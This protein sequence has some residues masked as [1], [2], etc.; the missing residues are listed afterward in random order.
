MTNYNDIQDCLALPNSYL[1]KMYDHL[2]TLAKEAIDDSDL[3]SGR[4]LLSLIICI[5]DLKAEQLKI[6]EVPKDKQ[7]VT[8]EASP[9]EDKDTT[10]RPRYKQVGYD[11][12]AKEMR[13][14]IVNLVANK[15]LNI[16]VDISTRSFYSIIERHHLS[17]IEASKLDSLMLPMSDSRQDRPRW[18]EAVT[19][20]LLLLIQEGHLTKSGRYTY[21]WTDLAKEELVTLGKVIPIKEETPVEEPET[22]ETLT[23]AEIKEV[24]FPQPFAAFSGK[25]RIYGTNGSVAQKR[26]I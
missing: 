24:T 23:L 20:A 19:Q 17:N 22:K 26:E 3:H 10:L 5:Q 13:D 4:R 16:N 7:T 18:K 2:E 6:P 11:E 9:A 21:T 25:P 14:A 15:L 1:Q 12:S 8:E